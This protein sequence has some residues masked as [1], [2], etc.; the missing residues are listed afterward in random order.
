MIACVRF[1]IPLVFQIPVFQ[2]AYRPKDG[3]TTS[4]LR[5]YLHAFGRL[6]VTFWRHVPNVHQ[7]YM[8]PKCIVWF[9]QVYQRLSAIKWYRNLPETL[10]K[11]KCVDYSFPPWK[12]DNWKQQRWPKN[13]IEIRKIIW[14]KPPWHLGF[15]MTLGVTNLQ[16][17]AKFDRRNPLA[18]RQRRAKGTRDRLPYVRWRLDWLWSANSMRLSKHLSS[19]IIATSHYLGPQKGSWGRDIPWFQENLGWG[20]IIIWPDS[21]QK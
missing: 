13:W 11:V 14:T 3:P 18:P 4:I 1:R 2:A 9:S 21:Y 7:K 19:Q 17:H 5:R 12:I 16:L 6:W 10:P 8:E 15:K 20:N